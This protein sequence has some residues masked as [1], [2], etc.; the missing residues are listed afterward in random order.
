MGVLKIEIKQ[1]S[2][3]ELDCDALVNPAN[4]YGLMGG[5]LALAI[6]RS[7]GKIIEEEAAAK[8]P[9]EVGSAVATSAGLLKFKA[10]IHVPT[11]K[12]PSELASKLNVALATRAAL[13]LADSLNFS[14]LAL[15]GMG[16]G[17]GKL[18]VEEAAEAM[19]SE[20][21]SFKATCLKFVTLCDLNA[22]LI[23]AWENCLRKLAC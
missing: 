4:S 23:T 20:I 21:L 16:T 22:N 15:P 17:V 11:M 12:Q 1:G 2:I 9:I 8:A 3:L 19:L 5:G 18:A 10:I 14:S 7:G 6:K 13:R